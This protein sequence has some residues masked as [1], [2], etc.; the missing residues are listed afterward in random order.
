MGALPQ[1]LRQEPRDTHEQGQGAASCSVA[2]ARGQMLSWT[3]ATSPESDL[4]L[5]HV[6]QHPQGPAGPPLNAQ[7][8][9][10]SFC[11]CFCCS[12][13]QACHSC[14]RR[15]LLGCCRQM[16]VRSY[17]RLRKLKHGPDFHL[18]VLKQILAGGGSQH[19]QRNVGFEVERELLIIHFALNTHT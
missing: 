4:S 16:P 6:S 7:A 18:R 10:T 2:A 17:T 9:F 8:G 15:C 5:T 12:L 19:F 3:H 13:C 11:L 14:L 1:R